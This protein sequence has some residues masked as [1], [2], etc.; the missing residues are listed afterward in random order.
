MMGITHATS[1]AAAW[2]A[3]TSSLPV[4]SLGAHPLDPVGVLAGA[5]VCAG[6]ALL[7]DADHR[8]ATV[9]RAVPVL[10]RLTTTVIGE[11]TGGHRKGAHSALAVLLVGLAAWALSLLVLPVELLGPHAVGAEAAGALAIGAGIGTAALTAFGLRAR[12]FVVSWPLAWFAGAL[13]GAFVAV[14]APEHAAWFPLAVAL[15]FAVHLLGDLL[16]VGGLPGLLWP[17]VPKPPRAL[18]PVPVLRRLWLPNGYVALPLLGRTG[19]KR[20]TALC[21]VLALYSFAGFGYEALQ[22][23]GALPGPL[24]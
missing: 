5:A 16:T 17:W 8:S 6:A 10:G 21:A 22:Y 15:G 4:L 11:L 9:A 13:L 14:A 1:G 23:I 18:R 2:V 19:S 3:L 24:G 12:R 20:E 7:P